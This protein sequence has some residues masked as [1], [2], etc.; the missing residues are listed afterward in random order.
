MPILDNPSPGASPLAV[1]L[2]LSQPEGGATLGSISLATLFITNQG[3]S[4]SKT[5][6]VV[7]TNDSGPGSLRQAIIDA[8]AD[9]SAG[10]DNIIF[11]I[12]ASTAANLNVPVAGFDPSTQTWTID[13]L[14][15]LPP[16]NRSVSID[17][18]TQASVPVSFRY[19]N[20][21]TSSDLFVAID[22]IPTGG[23]FTLTVSA[24]GSLPSG[25]TA[26]IPFNA[27]A[28]QIQ[29]ALEA[30]VGSTNGVSNAVVS[31]GPVNLAG[32]SVTFQRSYTGQAV[33]LNAQSTL[34]GGLNPAVTVFT[35]TAGGFPIGARP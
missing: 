22:G 13:L 9:A 29:S 5:F 27:T 34:T 8:N 24:P 12:P 23:S 1:S 35:I 18:Y 6:I 10:V 2:T 15:P 4:T 14:T 30:I 3:S 17:G 33:T 32:V 31:G 11:E 28:A 25:T 19:P 16:I 21:S 20:D 7:N 26:P